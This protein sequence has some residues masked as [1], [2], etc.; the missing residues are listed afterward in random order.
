MNLYQLD[1]RSI[2]FTIWKYWK[3]C[4]EKL[5]NDRT[6]CQQL[7]DLAPRQ[8][9]C[10]HGTVCEGVFSYYTNNCVGTPCLFTESSLQL[11]FSVPEDKGNI[12]RKA[13]W[14]HWWHQEQYNGSSEDH[15]TK[16]FP[17]LFWRVDWALASVRSFPR[18]VLWRRP[19]WHS[20]MR[21]VALLP[22]W[23]RELYCHATLMIGKQMNVT[24]GLSSW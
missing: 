21:Y 19:Q 2:K 3:G 18:G 24:A 14:W 10:S 17:K 16:S 11:L 20:T 7:M 4:V 13:F 8:C 15:S 23:V 12:E 9:T 5:N 22:R 1:K 6:F